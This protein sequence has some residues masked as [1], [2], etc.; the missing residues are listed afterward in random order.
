MKRVVG[1][2][3]RRRDQDINCR[4]NEEETGKGKKTFLPGKNC[5]EICCLFFMFGFFAFL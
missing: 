3:E 1:R 5:R 4:V 2:L